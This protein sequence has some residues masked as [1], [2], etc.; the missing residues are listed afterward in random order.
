MSE[1]QE[2]VLLRETSDGI[3]TLALNRPRQR[4]A[5]SMALMVNLM[6]HW[7]ISRPTQTSR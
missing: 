1:Q 5:L 4:N 6:Q 7:R 3:A 2:Q